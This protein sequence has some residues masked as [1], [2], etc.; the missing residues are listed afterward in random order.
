MKT[1]SPFHAARSP[2][3]TQRVDGEVLLARV[4]RGTVGEGID[5][6]DPIEAADVRALVLSAIRR[7]RGRRF[8]EVQSETRRAL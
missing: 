2:L 1:V 4:D 6:L 5:G 3:A 7:C 8:S